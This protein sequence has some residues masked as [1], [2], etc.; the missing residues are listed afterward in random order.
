MLEKVID[1]DK[2]VFVFLN[3]LGSPTFDSLWLFITKQFHWTPFFLLLAYL[4][5][6]KI[7]WKNL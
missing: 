6:R 2:E 3:G 5:Q 1:L 4:L 7:G